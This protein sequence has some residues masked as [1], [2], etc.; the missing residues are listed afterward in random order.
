MFF[1][2]YIHTESSHSCMFLF[3]NLNMIKLLSSGGTISQRRDEKFTFADKVSLS[4]KKNP[5]L[6]RSNFTR[7]LIM[8]GR[9]FEIFYFRYVQ[10]D[11]AENGCDSNSNALHSYTFTFTIRL[12]SSLRWLLL[13]SSVTFDR[14]RSTW[15]IAQ[16]SNA[17]DS[18]M[19]GATRADLFL[20][21]IVDRIT[22]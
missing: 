5:S 14:V 18:D 20:N 16:V 1:F 3:F 21:L 22:N 13:I 9:K 6:N 10:F 4:D 12:I 17:R 19:F 7:P 15:I 8:P 2:T 11:C